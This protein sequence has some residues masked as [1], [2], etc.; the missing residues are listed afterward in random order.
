LQGG[1]HAFIYSH[2]HKEVER[3]DLYGE[4]TELFNGYV[5]DLSDRDGSLYVSL[6]G[7]TKDLDREEDVVLVEDIDQTAAEEERITPLDCFD[8]LHYVYDHASRLRNFEHVAKGSRW[9]ED[10]DRVFSVNGNLL[11][12]AVRFSFFLD[13]IM[14]PKFVEEGAFVDVNIDE[15][16]TGET[17]TVKTQDIAA[18][19]LKAE[20]GYLKAEGDEGIHLVSDKV[21]VDDGDGVILRGDTPNRQIDLYHQEYGGV[22]FENGSVII[23]ADDFD[24]AGLSPSNEVLNVRDGYGISA[25][26]DVNLDVGRGLSAGTQL[27]VNR[28]TGGGIMLDA[29]NKL[30]GEAQGIAGNGLSISSGRVSL[31]AG[32]GISTGSSS[33]SVDL[34]SGGGLQINSGQVEVNRGAGISVGADYGRL[35]VDP[36]GIAGLGLK[37]SSGELALDVDGGLEVSSDQVNVDTD[38]SITTNSGQ[39]EVVPS[40]LVDD[41]TLIA[42]DGEV[43]LDAKPDFFEEMKD[44]EFTLDPGTEHVITCADTMV[45]VSINAVGQ[46]STNEGDYR[47]YFQETASENS[48]SM[49]VVV[50]STGTNNETINLRARLYWIK[51]D[52]WME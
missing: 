52:A 35:M 40:Q 10:N 41:S 46:T 24:G 33:T 48:D 2:P 49:E 21:T 43:Q 44:V 6:E 20:D 37:A 14:R 11:N 5:T 7:V 15:P 38:G 17:M 47:W 32:Y 30:Y 1:A 4:R 28:E 12:A 51:W 31:N 8:V 34:E 26:T 13:V 45:M 18:D 16:K 36:A 39:L 9:H 29:N 19:G 25:G 3:T 23:Q 22:Y 27:Y 50:E 42:F